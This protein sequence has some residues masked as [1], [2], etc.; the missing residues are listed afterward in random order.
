MTTD[1]PERGGVEVRADVEVPD[2]PDTSEMGPGDTI[3][4]INDTPLEND[5]QRWIELTKPLANQKVKLLVQRDSKQKTMSVVLDERTIFGKSVGMLG[6]GFE[7]T[8]MA[9]YP[10]FEAIRQGIKMANDKIIG[11]FQVFR[12]IQI[13]VMSFKTT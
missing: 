1:N 10:F 4:A 12:Q 7:L 2:P 9:G 6:V 3:L 11:I 5:V 13:Y 8:E